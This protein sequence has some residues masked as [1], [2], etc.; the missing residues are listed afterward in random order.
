MAPP[1]LQSKFIRELGFHVRSSYP[2][3]YVVTDEP[4]RL[5]KEVQLLAD[6]YLSK[7][8]KD[9]ESK[10]SVYHWD[11]VTG[12][13]SKGVP[14]KVKIDDQEIVATDPNMAVSMIE[15]DERMKPF[16]IYLMEN[17]HFFLTK[18][19][20]SLIQLAI[21]MS[22]HCN[23]KSKTIV[24]MNPVQEI[25]VEIIPHVTVMRHD[26]PTTDDINTAIDTIANI[27]AKKINLNITPDKRYALQE[28]LKGVRLPDAENSLSLSLVKEKDFKVDILLK[29]KCLA[30]Q[31]SG[32]LEYIPPEHGFEAIG[33]CE[34]VKNIVLESKVTLGP[35]A[36]E[37]NLEPMKALLFLGVPGCCKSDF[38]RA[39]GP[40]LG[41]PVIKMDLSRMFGS[42]VGQSEHNIR[43]ALKL[44]DSMAPCIAWIDEFDKGMSGVGG[45]GSHDGG[46]T[47]RVGG[48]LLTWMNDHI[49][50]VIVM[51]SAN[52]VSAIPPEYLR[53]GRFSEIVFFDIPTPKER[54]EI[55]R[56]QFIRQYL[57]PTK[58][59][60]HALVE[61]SGQFT[62]A[63]VKAAISQAKMTA[64]SRAGTRPTTEGIIEAIG[65]IIPEAKKNKSRIEA[66]R[67]K[68]ASM[69]V[70]ASLEEKS[71]PKEVIVGGQSFREITT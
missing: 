9:S 36:K 48:V 3:L 69:A 65:R 47:V 41:L 11:V 66:I 61:A 52:D 17:F 49:S 32:T 10:F 33:G 43:E 31:K 28:S 6:S 39:C 68:A 64:G 44:L 34:N 23:M 55:F 8:S 40:A 30:I 13:T 5:T 15:T 27:V 2:F 12:W 46:T 62:G 4:H 22:K 58:Y 19:N 45:S 51:C 38:I 37:L 42:L 7:E 59:D 71:A 1:I 53:K 21:N 54:A 60:I 50:Q 67:Q 63:E 18:E 35:K 29:E 56:V 20:P 14:I 16:S 26:L 70:P 25:P 57:D 24:F